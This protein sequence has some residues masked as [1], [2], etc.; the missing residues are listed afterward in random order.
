MQE[1]EEEVKRKIKKCCMIQVCVIY[2]SVGCGLICA[3]GMKKG[4]CVCV[5]V[6]GRVGVRVCVTRFLFSSIILYVW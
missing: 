5:C 3:I 1:E 4:A 6:C 2:S